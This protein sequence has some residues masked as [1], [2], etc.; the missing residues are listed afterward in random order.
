MNRRQLWL[1]ATLTV[2]VLAVVA[3]WQAGRV[4]DLASPI[5]LADSSALAD[6]GSM[7]VE[8]VDARGTRFAFGVEGSLDVPRGRFPVYVLRWAPV[9]LFRHI[10][11]GSPEE[12]QLSIL[13][14][15]AASDN[16]ENVALAMFLLQL[17]ETLELGAQNG[18]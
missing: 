2:A 12:R 8:L 5:V 16:V 1:W 14:R 15:R 18:S 3:W 6:G 4:P 10:D 9:P 13:A 11:R 7:H 17:A